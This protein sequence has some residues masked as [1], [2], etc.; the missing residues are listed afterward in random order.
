VK[1]KKGE[2]ENCRWGAEEMRMPS[3]PIAPTKSTL[4]IYPCTTIEKGFFAEKRRNA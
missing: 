1:D 2:E 4:P 3:L